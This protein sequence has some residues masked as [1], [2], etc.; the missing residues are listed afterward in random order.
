MVKQGFGKLVSLKE[1]KEI[2]RSTVKEISDEKVALEHALFRVLAEDIVSDIDV[3][4]F[5]KS[6]MDGFAVIASDTFGASNTIPKKLKIIDSVI[7]GVVSKKKLNPGECIE[8]TTGAPMPKSADAVVMVEYTEKG[9]E[10]IVFYKSVAPGDN[11]IKVGSDVRKG[12]VLLTKGILLDPRFTGLLSS[13][14]RKDVLV[15]KIP[16][17]SVL[18]TG[19][20][21][22]SLDEK[23]IEGKIYD[24]NSR[25]LIDSVKEM[26]CIPVDLGVVQDDRDLMKRKVLDGVEK[27]DLVIMS[28]GSSLGT[29]DLTKEVVQNLGEL[30]VHGIA[31]KPGKPVVI[32]RIKGKAF[33]GLPGYPTSALSDFHILIKPV[34]HAMLG[35]K[36]VKN[37]VRAKLSRKVASTIGRYEFL[38]VKLERGEE[39][40]IAVPVMKGS[41]AITTLSS[42]DG[43]IEVD[44]N[45]EV[46]DK[47]S[48]VKVSLF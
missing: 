39:D 30:L 1:A 7:A 32:G 17:V 38:A 29:E 9:N 42:A 21:I 41:S 27:S 36:E 31:V 13:I 12:S 46:L 6:A 48:M 16:R 37:F 35:I 18:S 43:F 20:E 26:H 23:L 10:K 40:L 45:T 3:P 11:V 44:E 8:I 5:R 34:I 24:I 14:G 25:T 22:I 4:H 33:I 28:G 19:N 47:G 15:K 2:I